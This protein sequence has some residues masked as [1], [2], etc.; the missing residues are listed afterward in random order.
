MNTQ[1][2]LIYGASGGI[3]QATAEKLNRE[4][5]ALHLVGRDKDRLTKLAKALAAS[6][7][8]GDVTDPDLFQRVN[9]EAGPQLQGLVYAIGTLKLRSLRQV[10]LDDVMHDFQVNAAGAAL[11]I[12]AAQP[13]LRKGERPTSVVLYSSVAASQ[14]FVNHVS[15]GMA[16][17]AISGLTVSLAAE[18][19]PAIRVNAVAPSLTETPLATPLTA[20]EK[21]TEAIKGMHALPRLGTPEDMASLTCYLLSPESSW[22]TGQVIGVDGGRSTLRVRS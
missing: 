2:I 10:S 21:M 13:A 8:I 16:K 6:F 12:Q 4:G 7:T 19:S 22:I 1:K 11:A 3:G 14:G 17:A 18:L 5:Y 15:I 20:N 9:E